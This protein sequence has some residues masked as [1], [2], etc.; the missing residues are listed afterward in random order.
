[1][2]LFLKAHVRGH[3][4][5]RAAG[6][7]IYVNPYSNRV[8]TKPDKPALFL[9]KH[10]P[11]SRTGDLFRAK[12]D[13]GPSKDPETIGVHG[14]KIRIEN[15]RGSTRSKTPRGGGP[16]WQQTM[17]HHYGEIAGTTG[18]DGD[19][20]DA[21]VGPNLDAPSVFVVNQQNQHGQFNEHKAMIGFASAE[22]A[23]AGYLAHY[24]K[25]WSGLQSMIEMQPKR[26]KR[27]LAR[28]DLKQPAA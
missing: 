28:G 6:G 11:D 12:P 9:R 15:P 2:I 24:P 14:L 5:R 17:L 18:G 23:R 16:A 7:V 10:P 21:Y 1:M 25:G 27:W 13:Q 8:Q 4:R 3:L 19:P 20:I 26:F 22:E